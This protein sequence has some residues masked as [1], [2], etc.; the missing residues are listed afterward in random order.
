[1]NQIFEE[2]AGKRA[3]ER[4]EEKKIEVLLDAIKGLMT[5]MKWTADQAMTVMNLSEQDQTILKTKF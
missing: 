2:L 1:M 3:E 5:S 4:A